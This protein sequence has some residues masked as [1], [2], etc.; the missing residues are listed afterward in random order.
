MC[1]CFILAVTDGDRNASAMCF[2]TTIFYTDFQITLQN[3]NL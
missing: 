2:S 3:V 1:M